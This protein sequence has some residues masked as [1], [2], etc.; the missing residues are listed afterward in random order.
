MLRSEDYFR[1]CNFLRVTHSNYLRNAVSSIWVGKMKTH[2]HTLLFNSSIT[3]REVLGVD[4]AGFMIQFEKMYNKLVKY[5]MALAEV[6]KAYFLV[7]VAN[8]AK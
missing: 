5:N 4:F 8:M 1:D 7:N 3:L 2:K 6:V